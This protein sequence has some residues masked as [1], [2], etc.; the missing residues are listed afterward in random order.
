[1]ASSQTPAQY[2]RLFFAETD[3]APSTVWE[4]EDGTDVHIIGSDD[5]IEILTNLADDE[6]SKQLRLQ[7]MRI[8]LHNGRVLPWLRHLAEARVKTYAASVGR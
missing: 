5:I 7:L 1:M 4:I 8:D 6:G 2:F 3:K